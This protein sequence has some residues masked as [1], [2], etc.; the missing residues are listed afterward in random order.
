[1]DFIQHWV[2]FPWKVEPVRMQV[3]LLWMTPFQHVASSTWKS[4][5]NRPASKLLT[6]VSLWTLHVVE[7]GSQRIPWPRWPDAGEQMVSLC[8]PEGS[9]EPWTYSKNRQSA[10]T[11]AAANI[12]RRWH[13]REQKHPTNTRNSLTNKN[14]SLHRVQIDFWRSAGISEL[15]ARDSRVRRKLQRWLNYS[16]ADPL[17]H[18]QETSQKCSPDPDHHN[19]TIN[20]AFTEC[21]IR[22]LTR[23]NTMTYLKFLKR[24]KTKTDALSYMSLTHCVSVRLMY[25]RRL[26][27]LALLWMSSSSAPLRPLENH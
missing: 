8:H 10:H 18:Q 14:R 21:V 13:C 6:H 23:N 1:M 12:W 4:A 27:S 9:R 16:L 17:L 25:T 24:V 11:P 2:D 22:V 20:S 5:V 7:L 19:S 15:Q 26:L 3:L